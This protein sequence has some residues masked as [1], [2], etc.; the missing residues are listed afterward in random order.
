MPVSAYGCRPA[1]TAALLWLTFVG[2]A[3]AA[4]AASLVPPELRASEQI[5]FGTSPT[6]APLEFKDPASNALSGLDI[7]L[8]DGIA[9]RLGLQ[10]VW[11][12]QGFE[13]LIPSLETRRIDVGASGMTDIP[14]RRGKTDFVDYFATGVQLFTF[15]PAPVG[16]T[17]PTDLCGKAVAVNRNGIF[18]IRTREFSETHCVAAGHPAI[19]LVLTDKTAD[20]RLQMM[21]GR[22][23]AAAQ[24]VDSIR[25]L[26]ESQNSADR[27]KFALIGNPISIDHAGFGIAKSRPALRDAVTAGV[28]EM[29]ADGSY[30]AIFRKWEMPY[31]QVQT[32]TIN[33]DETEPA[34]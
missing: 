12:E 8:G 5:R 6:Y 16:I 28:K 20:S 31:T 23:D 19:E 30:A 18:L 22:A 10:P 27:G 4:D 9:K 2:H 29:I 25:Y 15:A 7:D 33:G 11:I 14:A 24:G 32:V 21:P 3:L 17:V 13:Q 34:K 1:A 26:N